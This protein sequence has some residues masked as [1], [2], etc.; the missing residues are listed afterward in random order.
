MSSGII[1]TEQCIIG[2]L[3][4]ALSNHSDK[5]PGQ[6]VELAEDAILEADPDTLNGWIKIAK[7]EE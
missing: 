5:T 3:C 1:T 7:Q 6:W 2:F 4:S